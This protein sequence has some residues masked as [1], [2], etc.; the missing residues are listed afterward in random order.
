[1]RK[2][3]NRLRHAQARANCFLVWR[4][5][6]T[7]AA[8]KRHHHFG[9]DKGHP[10]SF[11]GGSGHVPRMF[12]TLRFHL[13]PTEQSAIWKSTHDLYPRESEPLKVRSAWSVKFQD[14]AS[15]AFTTSLERNQGLLLT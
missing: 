5:V 11:A 14:L 8:Q 6:T 10:G 2:R 1:M 7:K 13:G 12:A 3:A 15:R 4:G 9:I